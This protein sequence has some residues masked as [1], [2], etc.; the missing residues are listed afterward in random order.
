[1]SI[2][3]DIYYDKKGLVPL[4]EEFSAKLWKYMGEMENNINALDA[5]VRELGTYW[6]DENYQA[7][8]KAMQ[9][10]VRRT[11]DQVQRVAQLKAEI[12]KRKT[13]TEADLEKMRV[14]Y[15]FR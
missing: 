3:E 15:G 10:S 1:M 4:Y 9:D 14:K 5:I 11:E 8:K 12:D 13:E 2:Q 7:Y 6:T